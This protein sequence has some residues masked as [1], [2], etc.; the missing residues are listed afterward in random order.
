MASLVDGFVVWAKF[1]QEFI[2][3][4]RALV[5]EPLVWAFHQI[6]PSAWPRVPKFFFD[7]LV[8]WSG[9]F[10]GINIA[11]FRATGKTLLEDAWSHVKG[12]RSFFIFLFISL[13]M[14]ISIPFGMLRATLDLRNYRNNILF[15]ERPKS[16]K[17]V[18]QSI[19][20]VFSAFV[21]LLFINFRI[22]RIQG[23]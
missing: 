12:V 17:L 19:A 20:F 16:N 22:N 4:Y 6:W 8:I 1:F 23:H 21:L 10:I 18:A 7:L 5:R 9:L 13:L 2:D 14:F 15:P 3:I 11:L